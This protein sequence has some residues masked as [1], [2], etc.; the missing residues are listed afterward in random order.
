LTDTLLFRSGGRESR[1]TRKNRYS[2][3]AQWL[4][5]KSNTNQPE[6]IIFFQQRAEKTRSDID[7]NVADI[8]KQQNESRERMP[9]AP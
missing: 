2:A 1:D 8:F 4:S 7:R 9:S 5:T 3:P 6:L